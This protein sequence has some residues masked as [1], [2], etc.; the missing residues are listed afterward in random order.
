MDGSYTCG[1]HSIMCKL[2]KSLS[3]TPETN[4]TLCVSYTQKMN[5][6]IIKT[7]EHKFK[8]QDWLGWECDE[9]G[10]RGPNS[11]FF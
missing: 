1:E 2:V 4:E 3:C 8:A 9:P 10:T 5:E 7:H 6:K 11:H